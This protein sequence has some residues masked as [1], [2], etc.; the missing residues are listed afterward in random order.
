M[1]TC[2][3]EGVGT[4]R[5]GASKTTA[6]NESEVVVSSR[7]TVSLG[8]V[9]TSPSPRSSTECAPTANGPLHGVVPTTAPSTTTFSRPPEA[10]ATVRVPVARKLTRRA[11]TV[12]SCRP[13]TCTWV[14]KVSYPG[15]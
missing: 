7:T 13:A 12:F 3:L 9:P 5:M 4:T 14:S 2:A 10:S 6:R 11:L 1:F 8:G 15:L